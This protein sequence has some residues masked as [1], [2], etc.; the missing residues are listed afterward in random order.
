MISS[1]YYQYYCTTYST[2]IVTVMHRPSSELVMKFFF[3]NVK[4]YSSIH[5]L[6]F[7]RDTHPGTLP[8]LLTLPTNLVTLPV[9]VEY[10]GSS[11][12]KLN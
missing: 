10:F 5:L 7:V 2:V 4:S 8:V 1:H 9:I 3:N 11:S 6:T 12:S